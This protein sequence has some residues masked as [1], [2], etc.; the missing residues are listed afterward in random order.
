[1]IENI[2]KME[3][4]T[5]ALVSDWYDHILAL[6]KQGKGTAWFGMTYEQGIM[7]ALDYVTGESDE[8]PLD[9]GQG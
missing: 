4:R 6:A 3:K 5:E 2:D 9:G 8:H 1:M 7:A